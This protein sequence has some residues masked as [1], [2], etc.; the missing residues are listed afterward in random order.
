LCAE[1]PEGV[2]GKHP[3]DRQSAEVVKCLD[4]GH[5]QMFPLLTKEEYDKEYANDNTVL[6]MVD[7]SEE[8][9][10][11]ERMRLKFHQ[12]NM[13]HVKM[14]WDKLQSHRNVINLGSGYGFF[15]EACNNR[16][17]RKFSIEGVE[18]GDF[19]LKNYVGGVV[20]NID[21][22]N[23]PIPNEMEKRYDFIICMH[24]LEHLF[25][26]VKYLQNIKKL[27]T[28]EGEVLFEVPNTGCFLAELSP[29]YADFIYLYEHVSYYYADTL[30]MVF[31]RAGYQVIKVYTKELYSIENHIRWIR[32]GKPF[33]KYNMMFMPDERIEFINEE[34]K[35]AVGNMGKGY[36]LII[37]AKPM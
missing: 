18:I 7:K 23:D 4:C 26:P 12:W 1:A 27:L 10:D 21:F 3:R 28:D 6:K 33:T 34:Y 11:F 25:E 36:A 14:Y 30:K 29:E 37:E 19:R 13:Q 20:H 24:L 16:E 15:E 31:E 9:S 17:D 32:D 22:L 8:M 5:V 2:T 35:K